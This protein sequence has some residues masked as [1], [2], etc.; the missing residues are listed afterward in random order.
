MENDVAGNVST[1]TYQFTYHF[2][3]VVP[4]VPDEHMNGFNFFFFIYNTYIFVQ[5]QILFRLL[6]NVQI[7]KA[8]IFLFFEMH[9]IMALINIIYTRYRRNIIFVRVKCV[10]FLY[11]FRKLFTV[12]VN[13]M[14][15]Y[16]TYLYN[17]RKLANY[18]QLICRKTS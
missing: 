4:C 2:S 12:V 5:T 10:L 3:Y 13:D 15:N 14:K 17:V 7:V 11:E 6:F 18:N 9:I 16:H 8:F 1:Y